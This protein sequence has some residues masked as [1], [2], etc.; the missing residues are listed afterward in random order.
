[1][2]KLKKI[3]KIICFLVLFSVSNLYS[4]TISG[5]LIDGVTKEPIEMAHIYSKES[6][7]GT[8]SNANGEF[9]LMLPD[10]KAEQAIMI[11]HIGYQSL[12]LTKTTL[13]G[14]TIEMIPDL[15]LLEDV[16]VGNDAY[17][18]PEKILYLPGNETS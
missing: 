3:K 18:L 2:K 4:Q 11:S 5:K 7:V 12:T 16:I 1:M 8:I 17:K 15:I 6:K 9:I 10:R 14:N 13:N